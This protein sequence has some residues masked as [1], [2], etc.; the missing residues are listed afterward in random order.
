VG[1]DWEDGE[2]RFQLGISAAFDGADVIF[3]AINHQ[4]Y[5]QLCRSVEA[6]CTVKM[7]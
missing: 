6:M 3:Y 7:Q 4:V 1:K 5:R 2:L